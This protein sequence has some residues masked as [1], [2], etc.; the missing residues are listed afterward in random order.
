MSGD[1]RLAALARR[2]AEVVHDLPHV[3]VLEVAGAG[4]QALAW[5]HAAPGSSRTVLEAT[6]RYSAA[7][8]GDAL[9]QVPPR[10][11]SVAVAQQLA[12]LARRRALALAPPADTATTPRMGVAATATIATDR[13]KRGRRGAALAVETALGV[14]SLTV[15]LDEPMR[16]GLREH[17][18]QLVSALLV[19]LLAE[20]C[21]ID[22]APLVLQAAGVERKRVVEALLPAPSLAGLFAGEREVVAIPAVAVGAGAAATPSGAVIL[23]GAFDPWHAGH[24]AL[25]EAAAALAGVPPTAVWFELPVVNADKAALQLRDAWRRASQFAGGGN[26][27]LSRAPL[28]QQK[29]VLYPGATFVV[30][31]DTAARLLQPRFYGDSER[32]MEAALGEIGAA[33][34]RFLVACRW[35]PGRSEPGRKAPSRTPAAPLCLED[36]P[37]AP[38]H[39]DLFVP[40]PAAEFR[41]DLSSTEIREA[42]AAEWRQLVG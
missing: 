10:A 25:G 18:E 12:G 36:L 34:C 33:G 38:R 14:L 4:T 8:L 9:G 26:L 32:A 24:R 16:P 37:I 20:G 13:R 40:I 23:S 30:G 39:S 1:T 42:T 7:A 6:D 28:F 41:M 35:Q 2:L 21:G 22:A 17:E 27:L 19:A 11:V 3:A 31:A 15:D 29:A 5:L